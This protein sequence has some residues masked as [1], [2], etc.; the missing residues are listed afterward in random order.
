VAAAGGPGVAAAGGAARLVTAGWAGAD[1]A[2]RRLLNGGTVGGGTY[3]APWLATGRLLRYSSGAVV[4]LRF[5]PQDGPARAYLAA[6]QAALP[7]EGPSVAGLAAWLATRHQ[8]GA[9][10]TTLYAAAQ[11]SYLPAEQ[12]DH[13]AGGGWV[14]GGRLTPVTGPLA[15]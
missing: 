10:P 6:L 12:E 2:L 3:L 9:A 7:G 5:D 13:H 8:G 4:A 1:Q 11:V 15:G 14:T